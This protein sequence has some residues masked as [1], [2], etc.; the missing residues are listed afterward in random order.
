MI[1]DLAQRHTERR[2][3]WRPAR[4]VVS[5]RTLEVDVLSPGVAK[6]FV[7]AHHYSG[8]CAPPAHPIGLYQRGELAGVA[9]FGPLP[10]M[11]AHRHVFPTLSTTEGVTLGRFVLLE[12]VAFNAESWFI[13][14]CFEVLAGRGV[15]GVDSCADPRWGHIGQI[16]QATNGRHVGRTN[17]ATI[18]VFD[19]GTE[20][21]NR[22][23]GKAR[24]GEV[25]RRYAVDQLVARG[26]APPVPGEDMHAWVKRWRRELTRNLRHPGKY[27]YMWCLDRRRRR[28]V[29]RFAPLPYPKLEV[30]R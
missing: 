11:N 22:T 29:L 14:R 30:N 28:E 16:Y 8:T 12:S 24:R 2:I 19:D 7:D 23:E 17:P 9:A 3:T 25:G 10:S 26:A 27:R 1:T 21:S 6:A 18:H 13:A 20:L 5:T 4:D 15:V